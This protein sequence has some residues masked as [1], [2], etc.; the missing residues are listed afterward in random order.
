MLHR[1][2]R[3][4]ERRQAVLVEVVVAERDEG[5][6]AAAVMALKVETLKV[7]LDALR[8]D[9]LEVFKHGFFVS[10][11]LNV[12]VRR[13]TSTE[14]A[15]RHLTSVTDDDHRAGQSQRTDRLGNL[16]LRGL[17]EHH[18]VEGDRTRRTAPCDGVAAQEMGGVNPF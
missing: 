8:Q 18:H 13:A 9:A 3:G 12:G 1:A 4:G 15:G 17:V 2:Q 14:L 7:G 16:D 5:L 6:V 11:W 10:V